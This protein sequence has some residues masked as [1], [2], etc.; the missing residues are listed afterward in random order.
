MDGTPVPEKKR[1]LTLREQAVQEL[2]DVQVLGGYMKGTTA[3]VIFEGHDGAG[4]LVR[5]AYMM[6]LGNGKWDAQMPLAEHSPPT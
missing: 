5:G 1:E 6:S 3:A 2:A 4:W